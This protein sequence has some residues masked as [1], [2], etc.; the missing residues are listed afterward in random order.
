MHLLANSETIASEFVNVLNDWLTGYEMDLIRNYNATPAYAHSCASHDF[1][2]A[3][4]AM[5]TAFEAL[6]DCAFDLDNQAHVDLF[7]AAWDY[8]KV[9]HLTKKA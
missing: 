9:N 8:A 2:D 7:N 1:C 6:A 5:L 3:N 4:M